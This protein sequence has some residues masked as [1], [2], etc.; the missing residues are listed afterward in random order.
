MKKHVCLVSFL[1]ICCLLFLTCCRENN[2]VDIQNMFVQNYSVNNTSMLSDLLHTNY[3]LK[4]LQA[5]FGKIP[6]NE[7]AIYSSNGISIGQEFGNVNAQFPIECVRHPENH[8]C[9]SVYGVEEGGFYYVFWNKPMNKSDTMTGNVNNDTAYVYFTTYIPSLK[10][11]SDFNEI[12]EG[13]STAEDV[14]EID[15]AFEL[16][17]LM[18]SGIYSFSLLD[19]EGSVLEVR[20]KRSEKISQRKDLIVEEINI[21]SNKVAK[22]CSCLACIYPNDLP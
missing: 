14:A 8:V 9:Y 17:F 10:K 11:A 15:P 18:S 4:D 5:Y 3:K 20:Y 19:D 2:K 1:A 12:N 16:S 13:T 22:S 21:I 6:P 7:N